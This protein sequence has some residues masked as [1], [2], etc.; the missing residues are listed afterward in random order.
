M[1]STYLIRKIARERPQDLLACDRS[2][3][4]LAP[5]AFGKKDRRRLKIE[6]IVTT[7]SSNEPAIA[8]LARRQRGGSQRGKKSSKFMALRLKSLSPR[9]TTL[10]FSTGNQVIAGTKSTSSAL[11]AHI[12]FI[13]M[14]SR[15]IGKRNSGARRFCVQNI[16]AS[17]HFGYAIDLQKISKENAAEFS[18]DPRLFPGAR[19]RIEGCKTSFLLFKSGNAVITG[20]KNEYEIVRGFNIMNERVQDYLREETTPHAEKG[21]RYAPQNLGFPEIESIDPSMLAELENGNVF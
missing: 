11:L 14:I 3:P 5:Y 8:E 17:A 7:S 15:I 9:A 4:T 20:A 6:N 1:P 10:C 12:T 2:V 16:V 13:L 21:D 18:Y 19:A